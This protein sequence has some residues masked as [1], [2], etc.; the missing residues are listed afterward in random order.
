MNNG[1][2][3]ISVCA[4]TADALIEQIKRAEDLADFI[5]IR[6]D[7]LCES[8]FKVLNSVE[9]E[10]S[11]NKILGNKTYKDSI[12]L[13]F[14]PR[15]QGGKR[16]LSLQEREAFWNSGYDSWG[17]DFEEDV[18]E[19]HVYW[20]YGPPVI[21][22]YH[23]FSGVPENLFEI[24]KRIIFHPNAN[25]DVVK[26]AV[27]ANDITDTIPIWKLLERAKSENKE[28]IP[29]AMGESGKW[30]R[31]LGLA[32]GAFLAY[33]ALDSG[34]ETAPGQ[35]SAKDLTEV[36]RVKELD[37]N[38]NIYGVIAGNTSYSMS[39]YIHNA[40]F[41][42]HKLNAVFV[43]LQVQNLDE[44]MRRMVLPETREIELNFRGFA[45]TN[46]HKQTIIRYLDEIDETAKKIG[47]VNTVK[48]ENG[49]LFGY[50]TDAQGFIEPLKNSYGDL[51]EAKVAV[52]GA[53]GAARACIY[54]LKQENAEITIFARNPEKAESLAKE[55][56]IQLEEFT[57]H[58]SP[59][60]INKDFEI[61][62]NTTPL[63]TKGEFENETPVAA[64]QLKNAHLV[65]D[66]VY[67][68]FETRLLREA[69]KADV[70]RIGGLAML[71]A[72]AAA[73]QKIWTKLDAPVQEMSRAALRKL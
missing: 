41:K 8:E 23:D 29:I 31:I 39:P 34:K 36:Y 35:V 26:I 2:I 5:E 50:N 68:P 44:F 15:E 30:T 1:K 61:L 67:N 37:K 6:F 69:E 3:C 48:I 33:A 11:F 20:L 10:K 47:A 70:P 71:I 7:C 4:E 18:V 60:T 21:C 54:A 62:V 38:T 24:Y 51:R 49:K 32:H 28:I 55:F 19:N 12:I 22:S 56:E 64:E 27:Q 43:P 66:L 16:D 58:H 59:F 25:V 9:S 65:Y 40:A 14:R 53:G 42:F 73:Q 45:V 57:I 52:F 13:T 63:G 72:Q 46:P 17:G